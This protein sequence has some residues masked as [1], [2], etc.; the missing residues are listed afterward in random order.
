[1][2]NL[3]ENKTFIIEFDKG[4]GGFDSMLDKRKAIK[5]KIVSQIDV[6]YLFRMS[7]VTVFSDNLNSISEK[8]LKNI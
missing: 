2:K 3:H 7:L 8:F 6:I 4:L 5:D 1:M